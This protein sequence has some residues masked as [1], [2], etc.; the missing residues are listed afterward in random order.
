MNPAP[1]YSKSN[2]KESVIDLVR[3]IYRDTLTLSTKEFTAAKLEIKQELLKAVT[4]A[5]SLGIGGFVLA[6]G[7]ILLSIMLALII[8]TYTPVPLWGGFGIIGL[9]YTVVGGL[10]LLAAKRKV[11]SVKPYPEQSVESAKE[12]VRYVSARASGH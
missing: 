9:F 8:A 3:G 6:V 12:D 10:L 4:A 2:G 5:I 11:G 1:N 7:I